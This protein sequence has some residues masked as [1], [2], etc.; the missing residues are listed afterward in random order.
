MGSRIKPLTN[1]SDEFA[2]EHIAA[3]KTALAPYRFTGATLVNQVQSCSHRKVPARPGCG[4]WA[5]D[6]IP[7]YSNL[8]DCTYHIKR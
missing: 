8:Q 7:L 2:H 3:V 1:R 5:G 4:I 6:S